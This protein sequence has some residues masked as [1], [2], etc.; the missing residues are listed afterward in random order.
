MNKRDR[1]EWAEHVAKLNEGRRLRRSLRLSELQA[2]KL[3]VTH[4]EMG[5]IEVVKQTL[6]MIIEN[7]KQEV[8]DW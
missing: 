5:N 7:I 4:L 2:F 3:M 8:E 6:T 1:R